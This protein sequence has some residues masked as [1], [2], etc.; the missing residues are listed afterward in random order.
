MKKI[1]LA[2]AALMLAAP[3]FAGEP[4][5][6]QASGIILAA[7]QPAPDVGSQAY[8]DV[9]GRPGSNLTG[10][11]GGLL[12]VTG[13]EGSV[14]T[15][16]SLPRYAA[17]GTVTYTQAQSVQRYLV[18]KTRRSVPAFVAGVPAPPSRG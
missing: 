12:P 18:S 3:A 9:A 2:A 4:L 1:F 5:A 13:S 15:A 17:E 6:N 10:L 16:N 8:P 11:G 14:E 7:Q